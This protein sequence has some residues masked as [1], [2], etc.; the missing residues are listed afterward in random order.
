VI[1][2]AARQRVAVIGVGA[3]TVSASAALAI[4]NPNRG[5]FPQCPFHRVTGLWCPG[6]GTQRA[7]H[8]LFHLDVVHAFHENALAMC[9]LPFLVYAYVAWCTRAFAIEGVPR[10][11]HPAAP[12]WLTSA[13]PA[14]VIGFALVRN[15]PFGHAFAP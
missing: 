2:T 7:L 5:G 6:C 4:G 1:V 14:L 15:L 3:A 9:A 12:V 10:L 11:R 13:L 8:A